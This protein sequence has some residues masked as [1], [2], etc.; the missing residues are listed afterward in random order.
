MSA[1][2]LPFVLSTVNDSLAECNIPSL[3]NCAFVTIDLITNVIGISVLLEVKFIVSPL[4]KVPLTSSISSSTT[5]AV[6]CWNAEAESTV[7]VALELSPVI[8]WPTAS[9]ADAP[10]DSHLIFNFFRQLPPDIF[11]TFSLG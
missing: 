1:N 2:P 6:S 4:S 9:S 3:P 10:V 8:I 7:A 11:K 5:D